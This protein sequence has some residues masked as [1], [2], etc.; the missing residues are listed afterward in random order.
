MAWPMSKLVPRGMSSSNVVARGLGSDLSPQTRIPGCARRSLRTC[1]ARH[2][3][4]PDHYDFNNLMGLTQK[5]MWPAA[6]A[7]LHSVYDHSDAAAVQTRFD[8]L[9]DYV[10]ERLPLSSTSTVPVPR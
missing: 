2:G 6:K 1:P 4:A 10:E 5:S 9:L 3:S 7:M 8:P